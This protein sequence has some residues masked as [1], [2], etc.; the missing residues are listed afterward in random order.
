MRFNDVYRFSMICAS[1][2]ARQP[3][4]MTLDQ[5]YLHRGLHRL[6]S[7]GVACGPSASPLVG[8]LN[9]EADAG[10]ESLFNHGRNRHEIC[11]I[12][13]GVGK[14]DHVLGLSW[15]RVRHVRCRSVLKIVYLTREGW[16]WTG[17]N[18]GRGERKETEEGREYVSDGRVSTEH[19]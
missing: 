5:T 15:G 8:F 17:T 1:A 7:R 4:D 2:K 18:G 10:N 9:D 11:L 16:G 6:L 13:L 14:A 3:R 19:L 12:H